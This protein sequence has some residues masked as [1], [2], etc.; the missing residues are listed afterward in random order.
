[1]L[2]GCAGII[3]LI[4]FL[5]N[6]FAVKL[7]LPEYLWGI[8]T[9]ED[10]YTIRGRYPSSA[11][12]WGLLRCSG[13]Q[14]ELLPF[15]M[16]QVHRHHPAGTE[17]VCAAGAGRRRGWVLLSRAQGRWERTAICSRSSRRRDGRVSPKAGTATRREE[18]GGAWSGG[19]SLRRKGRA[20]TAA[21]KHRAAWNQNRRNFSPRLCSLLVGFCQDKSFFK[22]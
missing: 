5:A 8:N 3:A 17:G 22:E 6:I 1:M 19:N 18:D 21:S 4:A 16:S 11:P 15:Q 14:P 7:L 12:A 10:T 20:P 13:H 9:M 2:H